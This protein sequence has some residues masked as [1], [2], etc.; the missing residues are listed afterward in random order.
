VIVAGVDQALGTSGVAILT[1]S[2]GAWATARVLSPTP[3]SLKAAAE[4]SDLATQALR[5]RS[6]AAAIAARVPEGASVVMEGLAYDGHDYERKLAGLR[7]MLI[8]ALRRRGCRVR[9]VAPSTRA[10]YATGSGKASKEQV[11]AAVLHQYPG[12]DV[13]AG[14]SRPDD[15]VADAVALAALGARM[16]GHPV[17]A[18]PTGTHE[19]VADSL[20]WRW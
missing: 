7:W 15:N 12:A 10:K 3:S 9:Q 4:E 2:T 16:A 5:M 18:D 1:T 6:I 19:R 20:A 13:A 11:V 8:D 17:E 14:A